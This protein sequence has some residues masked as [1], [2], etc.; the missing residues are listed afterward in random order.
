MIIVDIY[1]ADGSGLVCNSRSFDTIDEA[2][3]FQ[4]AMVFGYGLDAEIRE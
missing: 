3:A 4:E 2:V 1:R